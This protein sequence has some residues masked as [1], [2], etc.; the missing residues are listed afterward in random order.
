MTSLEITLLYLL[1]AVMSVV[2]CRFFHCPAMLGYLIAGMI[3]GPTIP[4]LSHEEKNIAYLAEFGVVFLMFVIG[5]EFNLKQLLSMRKSIFG[6][7]TAQVCLTIFSTVI[8]CYLLSIVMPYLNLNWELSWQGSFALGA[9]LSMS[10]SAIVIK[11]I[12]D[13]A[14]LETIYGRRVIGILLFQDIAV[15]PLLVLIPALGNINQSNTGEIIAIALIKSILL[16]T[17]VLWGGKGLMRKWL[18]IVDGRNSEELFMLN[19]L[20]LTLGLAWITEHIGLSLATGAF[21]TGILIA[22]TSYKNRVENQI[23]P[24]H[25]LLL[26]L[27]FITIGAKLNWETVYLNWMWVILLII[28][29]V[30]FKALLILAL[31]KLLGE[32]TGT[33]LRTSLYLAQAGE[34]GFVLLALSTQ[35]NLIPRG[36]YDLVIAAMIISMIATPFIIQYSKKLVEIFDTDEWLD[37]SIQIT[38]MAISSI[39]LDHHIIICGYGRSG[40]LLSNILKEKGIS[41]IVLEINPDKVSDGINNDHHVKIGDATQLPDLLSLGLT[42]ASA[43]VISHDETQSTLITINLIVQYSSSVPIIVRTKNEHDIKFLKKAGATDVL[44]EPLESSLSLASL[45]LSRIGEAESKINELIAHQRQTNYLA[46]E[47]KIAN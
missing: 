5:L 31:T 7:G 17:I 2:L 6:F 34:F 26:G 22:E 21:L 10:S 36:W 20:L 8:T 23:K 28:I 45:M 38:N 35:H 37:R 29:P 25:D 12:A 19:I 39:D 43:V 9:A 32:K 15:I 11:L 41:Y 13:R 18:N 1:A 24:F 47:N 4:I 16:V 30:S 3:L 33:S 14:E 40:R 46:F 44:H 27:F 42:R